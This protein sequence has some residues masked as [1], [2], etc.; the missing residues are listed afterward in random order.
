MS[1]RQEASAD[2][3]TVT[4]R[5]MWET[6]EMKIKQFTII[7]IVCHDASDCLLFYW[8]FLLYFYFGNQCDKCHDSMCFIVMF[9]KYGLAMFF[10]K[11]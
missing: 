5:M 1:L 10:E 9:L 6:P 2:V 7:R 4:M 8:H 11:S 3:N